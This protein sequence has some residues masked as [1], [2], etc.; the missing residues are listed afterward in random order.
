MKKLTKALL[1]GGSILAGAFLSER[2]L[3]QRDV[4]ECVPYGTRIDTPYGKMNVSIEGCGEPVIV[5]LSGYGTAA[6]LLDFA[7]LATQMRRQGHEQP[8]TSVKNYMPFYLYWNIK[9]IT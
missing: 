9:S 6:P 8:P 5:L 1:G 7:P 2:I 4:N 3:A